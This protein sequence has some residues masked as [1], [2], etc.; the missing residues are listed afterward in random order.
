MT[1]RGSCKCYQNPSLLPSPNLWRPSLVSSSVSTLPNWLNSIIAATYVNT[2]ATIESLE[3]VFHV[4]SDIYPPLSASFKSAQDIWLLLSS[5]SLQMK[6][7]SQKICSNFKRTNNHLSSRL[8]KT[9]GPKSAETVK[10][11]TKERMFLCS[12]VFVGFL[13]RAS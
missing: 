5:K 7:L 3:A 12:S 1:S 2:V 9:Q 4:F 10:D 13:P 8:G 6:L 11:V